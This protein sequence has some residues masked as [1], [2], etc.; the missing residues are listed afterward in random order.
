M[1]ARMKIASDM[2]PALNFIGDCLCILNNGMIIPPWILFFKAPG[3]DP[4][5]GSS[6][7]PFRSR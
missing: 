4:A 1:A 5:N 2:T 6:F 7:L 3:K